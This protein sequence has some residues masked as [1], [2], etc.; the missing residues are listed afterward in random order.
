MDIHLPE[1]IKAYEPELKFFFDNM[2]RKLHINRHKG[3][4]DGK[5]I[6]EMKSQ[7]WGEMNELSIAMEDEGQFEALM[8]CADVAN[9]AWLLGMIMLRQTKLEFEEQRNEA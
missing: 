5:T 9:Q 7:L 4:G 2:V 3:F 8:E 1:E 6:K